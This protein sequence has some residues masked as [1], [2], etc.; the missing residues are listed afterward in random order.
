M[1]QENAGSAVLYKAA[2][3]FETSLADVAVEGITAP[4]PELIYENWDPWKVQARNIPY[5]RAA[6]GVTLWD[7]AW[8]E[9]HKREWMALSWEFK[10]R[11]GTER[12]Y[13]M[14]LEQ[15][16]YGLT[17]VVAPPQGFYVSPDMTPEE[18]N[19][20]I[21]LM[22]EIRLLRAVY[23]GHATPGEIYLDDQ[24]YIDESFVTFDEAEAL[25]GRR[26]IMRQNGIDTPLRVVTHTTEVEARTAIEFER[27]HVPGNSGLFGLYIDV[28]FL[29]DGFTDVDIVE[30]FIITV[31]FDRSFN[32][33]TDR[34][35]LT[36]I[37]SG[38]QPITP[39]WETNSEIRPY[40]GECYADRGFL[41]YDFLGEDLG[42]EMLAERI[43]L[44]DPNVAVRMTEADS[45]LDQ[46]RLGIDPATAELLIDVHL[47]DEPGVLR[48]DEGYLDDKFA[49]DEDL[50]H[51]A[52]AREAVIAA[53][54]H[55]DRILV[56]FETFRPIQL[57][58]TL[59]EA[60]I[61]DQWVPNS[62]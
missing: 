47:K 61:L 23:I 58:D 41:D 11:R 35:G 16:G 48:I 32:A 57:G 29:D 20:W 62:L 55:R 22:P 45:Y 53:K 54:A 40:D 10:A 19:E 34:L 17:Q 37:T 43:Y 39:R 46:D 33:E 30:P 50:T 27:L 1:M 28:G 36:T 21:R 4:R 60:S 2:E 59:T 25:R 12:A 7:D 51:L 5:L 15:F 14:A 8:S 24:G 18:R 31:S 6:L 49:M 52:R 38:M 9:N 44:H 42:A 56:S 13:R 26:A 3:P